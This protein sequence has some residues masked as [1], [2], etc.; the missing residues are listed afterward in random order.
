MTPIKK[1]ITFLKP[2]STTQAPIDQLNW[3]TQRKDGVGVM[4]LLNRVELER[5]ENV[6]AMRIQHAWEWIEHPPPT[7]VK[8]KRGVETPKKQ[9][10]W[11]YKVHQ[12]TYLMIKRRVKRKQNWV[13]R[14]WI[15]S[16]TEWYRVQEVVRCTCTCV[17]VLKKDEQNCDVRCTCTGST[18][19]SYM[20]K[21]KI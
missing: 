14:F 6:T 7:K 10:L 13:H 1:P 17:P 20:L 21:S 19:I 16:G 18:G 15:C 9:D 4:I 11:N 2:L 3:I 5:K 12:R 8:K